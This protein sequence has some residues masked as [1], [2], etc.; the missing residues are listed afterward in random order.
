MYLGI[1]YRKISWITNFYI[2]E[3]N[4]FQA[5][6]VFQTED[7]ALAA[8]LQLSLNEDQSA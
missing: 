3:G 5:H 2:F 1:V 4:F 7:E 8:A 6:V